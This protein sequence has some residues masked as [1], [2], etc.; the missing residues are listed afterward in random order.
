MSVTKLLNLFDCTNTY[1]KL[2]TKED[3]CEDSTTYNFAKCLEDGVMQK[4]GCRP[5]WLE[6]SDEGSFIMP[7]CVQGVQFADFLNQYE[8]MGLLAYDELISNF[9]CPRPCI[10]M[11]YKVK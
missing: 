10:Y 5:Y 7:S 9:H 1:E 4:V 3:P 8:K 2:N 6:R 11:E